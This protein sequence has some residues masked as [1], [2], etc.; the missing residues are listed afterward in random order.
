MA[1]EDVVHHHKQHNHCDQI[2]GKHNT[3]CFISSSRFGD[4]DSGQ[5]FFDVGV[6]RTKVS[7]FLVGRR[8]RQ[9]N[10]NWGLHQGQRRIG[11]LGVEGVGDA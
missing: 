7:I 10:W 3:F 1:G 9:W 8:R 5:L 2:Q 4:S 6:A 11:G